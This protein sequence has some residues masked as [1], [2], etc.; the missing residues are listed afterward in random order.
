[1]T[2]A[3]HTATHLL[4]WALREK[5]GKHVKQAGSVVGPDML[6]FDFA[7]FESLTALQLREIEDL[8]N[9]KIWAQEPVAKQ[10]MEKDAA[11]ASGAIAMFG[12]SMAKGC[13]S[14]VW[15]IFR[16]SFVAALTWTMRE[17]STPLR[18]F[19][20][21]ALP[22]RPAHHRSDLRAAPTNTYDRAMTK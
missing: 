10:E 6:R 13:E 3:N 5:L 11:V 15:E 20:K 9:A 8:I 1:M 17:K 18:S 22:R 14:S 2:A 12:E 21:A 16:R 7:H 19:P 4:H